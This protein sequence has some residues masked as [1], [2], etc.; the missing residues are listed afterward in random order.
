V[1]AAA[2][3]AAYILRSRPAMAVACFIAGG[4]AFQHALAWSEGRGLDGMRERIIRSG[5][6]E[7]AD[8][9]VAQRSLWYV[10]TRYEQ[11][12]RGGELGRYAHSKAPG[13]VLAYMV[14]ERVSGLFAA[15]PDRDARLA[16]L[17]TTAAIAWPLVCYLTILPLYAVVRSLADR[18]TA[19]VAC[20]WYMLVPSVA[21]ITLHTDQ[22]LFPLLGTSVV[23]VAMAA[24]SRRSVA[25]SCLAGVCLWTGGFFTFPLLLVC[26][27]AAGCAWAIVRHDRWQSGRVS[28][29][30]P[31]RIVGGIALG[32]GA[33][34]VVFRYAFRYDVFARFADARQFNAAWKGWEGGAYQTLYFAWM[35]LLEFALWIGLPLTMLSFGR[36][37]RAVLD[38]ARGETGG[39][40]L[41]ALAAIVVL[42]TLA[43][44]GQAKGETARLWL[45]MVPF[46]VALAADEVRAR[47]GARTKPVIVLLFLLQWLTVLLTKSG[48][49]F[50]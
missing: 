48:Q 33:G 26:A 42:G 39:L 50:F 11:K 31:A 47:W 8:V 44:F 29:G 2:L 7:F 14:T 32:A 43:F 36:V 22:F 40:T 24:A 30:G 46:C 13:T 16:A 12:V 25:L 19:L 45:F 21:L 20:A 37:R 5:H 23:W 17:R 18:N 34:F 10:A 41:P 3:A 6:A 35:N 1:P 28:L 9:A 38:A 4:F 15:G 27:V 49:D